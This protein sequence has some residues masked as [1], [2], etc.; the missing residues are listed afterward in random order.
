M[1]PTMLD[2]AG[3]QYLQKRRQTWYVRFPIPSNLRSLYGGRETLVRSLRTRDLAEA[4]YLRYEAIVEIQREF[5]VK[6][7]GKP[8]EA[9]LEEALKLR[10]AILRADHRELDSTRHSDRDTLEFVAE[11]MAEEVEAV[12]G[13]ATARTVY[14]IATGKGLPTSIALERW[15]KD[16]EGTIKNGTVAD[17]RHAVRLFVEFSGDICVEDV[18]RID[19]GRF[20]TDVLKAGGQA[21]AKTINKK[22]SSLSALWKWLRKRG[23]VNEENP[24]EGQGDYTRRTKARKA[25]KRAYTAEELVKLLSADPRDVYAS[26]T[27]APALWDLMRLGLLTGARLDELCSLRVEDIDAKERTIRIRDGKT[28]NAQRTIPVLDPI[29]PIIERR[30]GEAKDGFLFWQLPPGGPDKK[31]GWTTT[32]RF[33]AF[34]R[35]VLGDTGTEL[36]FHSFRR[37]FATY[38]ERASTVSR[39]VNA[40]VIAELMGHAKGT[41]ALDG[42]SSGLRLSEHREA[43]DAMAGVIEPEVLGLVTQTPR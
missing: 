3:N 2:M 41:L 39:A 23:L 29:W 4:R 14:R 16:I 6:S 9:V 37:C 13:E 30:V 36:D 43:L 24:W 8:P 32:K 17:H 34:R 20:T 11:T 26:D 42:Y 10:E 5:R 25:E 15:L 33:T 1:K 7:T 12:H 40:S 19:A 18:A 35:R 28:E 22:L 38:L 31:R 21:S 27:Y